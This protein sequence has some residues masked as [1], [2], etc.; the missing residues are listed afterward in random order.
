[1]VSTFPIKATKYNHTN[2]ARLTIYWPIFDHDIRSKTV[3]D[4]ERSATP[5]SIINDRASR[6]DIYNICD[7]PLRVY[8][9]HARVMPRWKCRS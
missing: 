2:P 4:R 8:V 3:G 1:M 5:N 7:R 6:Y 9:K